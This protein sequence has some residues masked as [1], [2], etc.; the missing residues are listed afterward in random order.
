MKQTFSSSSLFTVASAATDVCTLTG[1]ATKNVRVRRAIITGSAT[2]V[3][4][5]PVEVF[6][7]STANSAGT[8]IT[9]AVVP[10]DSSNSAGTAVARVYTANPTVGTAVGVLAIQYLTY[11]NNTTGVGAPT[12]F[13]FGELGQP[14]VLRGVAQVFAV[15]LAGLTVSGA[16]LGCTIE[17]TEE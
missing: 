14:I 17:W 16:Q 3:A 15:N 12:T 8:A 5:E 6:K 7:R 11:A 1:S 2:S 9:G 10:Y 13:V 4:T